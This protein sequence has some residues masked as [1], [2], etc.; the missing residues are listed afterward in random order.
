VVSACLTRHSNGLFLLAYSVFCALHC[1]LW[2]YVVFLKVGIAMYKKVRLSDRPKKHCSKC[3]EVTP[4]N[5]HNRCMVCQRNRSNEYAKRKKAAGGDF[6]T[7]I[8]AR[9]KAE[10]QIGCPRC[11][12]PWREIPKHAQHPDTP[13]HF[14]HRVSLHSGGTSTDSNAQIMCWPCN[15]KKLNN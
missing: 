8:K 14:D 9:L 4:W 15:L 11:G 6:S 13:W 10:N 1:K 3:D 2:C 5:S 12:R 7:E